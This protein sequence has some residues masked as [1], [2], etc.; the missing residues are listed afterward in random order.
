MRHRESQVGDAGFEVIHEACDRSRCNT[1]RGG[2]TGN[3]GTRIVAIEA[4]SRQT[5]PS[6]IGSCA[7]HQPEVFR[8]KTARGQERRQERRDQSERLKSP[9]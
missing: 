6:Q 1:R 7:Q 2:P 3:A 9:A 4:A 5:A 8:R